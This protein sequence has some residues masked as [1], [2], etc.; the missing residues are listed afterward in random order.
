MQIRCFS[1]KTIEKI[2]IIQHTIT[3]WNGIEQADSQHCQIEEKLQSSLEAIFCILQHSTKQTTRQT[4]QCTF[5]VKSRRMTR[6]N[7]RILL[8]EC[9]EIKVHLQQQIDDEQNEKKIQVLDKYITSYIDDEL[10][11]GFQI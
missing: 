6:V 9:E 7:N 8:D 5:D 1:S 3:Q 11:L 2:Q 4:S 10:R